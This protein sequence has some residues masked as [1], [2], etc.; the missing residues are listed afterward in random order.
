MGKSQNDSNNDHNSH[1]HGSHGH[2]HSHGHGHHHAPTDFSK[3]FFFGIL[4]NLGFVVIEGIY[5]YAS[6]SLALFADAGH[7]LGDVLGLVIAWATA[8]LAKRKPSGKYTYGLKNSSTLAA[9]FNAAFLLVGVGAIIW[10]AVHRFSSPAPVAGGTV[11]VVAAIGIAVNTGTALLFM[12]G[13]H[14]DLNVRGAFLH[15]ASDAVVSLGVVIAGFV[16]LK[17][18]W[19]WVDPVTSIA[20]SLVI[21]VGTWNLLKDSI[22]LA[23]NAVPGSVE[24]DSVHGYLSSLAGVA[25]VHD[26]HIWGMG[27]AEVAMT[28][29]LVMPKGHPG[30]NFLAAAAQALEQKYKIHHSTLQIEV[31]DT[32]HA[33]A[34]E[35]EEVV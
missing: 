13:R 26:L 28:A 12:S 34:L 27:T 32:P 7:N 5:G 35:S 10:E 18:G 9:L 24:R 21:I 33:C 25:K 2:D 4:L 30:D 22:D 8:V 15:M 31:D 23:L 11:I 19:A 29:H 1:D 14:G 17:T 20:I 6:H 16:V 3:A